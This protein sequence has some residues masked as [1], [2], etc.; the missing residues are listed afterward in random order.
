LHSE[1][2]YSNDGLKA[3]HSVIDMNLSKQ[4]QNVAKNQEHKSPAKNSSL[5]NG[6]IMKLDTTW[7]LRIASAAFYACASF[8]IMVVNKRI[9]TVYKFPSF[10]VL[11]IGQ[12]IST[13]LILWISRR[14]K[15][16]SF[17]PFSLSIVKKV[18]PLPLFYVGNMIFGLGGTQ[19]LSLPMMTVLRRF[20]VLMTMVLEYFILNVRPRFDVQLSVF[21]MIFG[22]LVAAINDLAFNL[23]GYTYIL[24]NDVF[25]AGNGVVTK[26][27]L[28][29]KD[30]GK[31]GLLF[32]NA[33]LML[34]VTVLIAYGTG[35][36]TKAYEYP[37]WTR[38]SY[39]KSQSELD[40]LKSLEKDVNRSG[41]EDT[42]EEIHSINLVFLFH[43]LLSCVFGFILMFATLLCTQ[44]NS[45]L[46]TTM[47]GCLKNILLTYSGMFIGGDYIFSWWNF[48]GLNIS[49]AATLMYTNI[50]FG[51]SAKS[52]P[53]KMSQDSKPR[54]RFSVSEN[55]ETESMTKNSKHKR[56]DADQKV[57]LLSSSNTS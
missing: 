30:L 5:T 14:L 38:I 55:D 37:G 2:Q 29:A 19:A 39:S 54:D 21:L 8:M 1:N 51:K 57:P 12:M 10:Q 48:L 4:R 9:L 35:D 42:N 32:S 50:T 25:T 36:L 44:Y 31:Y 47:I 11:G 23:P 20:S 43:F 46:T 18:M 28:D 27:K 41:L 16:V 56:K 49:A 17:P 52:S 24:L 45:A 33:L 15:I 6:S 22:A 26:K 13:I 40:E 3:S 7:F 53:I 34:P